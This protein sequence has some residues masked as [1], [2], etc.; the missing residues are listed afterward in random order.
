MDDKLRRELSIN[1]VDVYEV[2]FD[3]GRWLLVAVGLIAC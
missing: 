2:V 1:A 3:E